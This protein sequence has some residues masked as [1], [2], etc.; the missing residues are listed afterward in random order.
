MTQD[1]KQALIDL[2]GTPGMRVLEALIR[3]KLK[4]LDSVSE[5]DLKSQVGIGIQAL[6][7]KK[8]VKILKDFLTD[9][10]FIPIIK[11]DNTYE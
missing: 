2:Q 3:E 1:E 6:A 9:L 5:I 10:S 4:E 7:Q 8:A 11:K